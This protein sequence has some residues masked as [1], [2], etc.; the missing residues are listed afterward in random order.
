VDGA[1]VAHFCAP[2]THPAAAPPRF[3]HSRWQA[4][5]SR[6]ALLRDS[7]T[8][9][10]LLAIS[11]LIFELPHR[12]LTTL[13]SAQP[14]RAATLWYTA[15][16][17]VAAGA[18]AQPHA[19][20]HRHFTRL[21]LHVELCCA[22]ARNN[23]DHRQ[24]TAFYSWARMWADWPFGRAALPSFGCLP[25][26]QWTSAAEDIA[27]VYRYWAA[28]GGRFFADAMPPAQCLLADI[29]RTHLSALCLLPCARLAAAATRR[30]RVYHAFWDGG[31]R[32]VTVAA[33][34]GAGAPDDQCHLDAYVHM[35]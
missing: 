9:H 18:L 7:S 16:G 31:R 17:S 15:A 20:T 29:F 14:C 4:V 23:D 27:S 6:Y 28:G 33:A 12:A 21:T 11:C 10:L 19:V 8:V 24:A 5:R 13:P 34:A 26:I 35:I 3:R 25:A 30:T 32:T 2:L 1:V 22:V